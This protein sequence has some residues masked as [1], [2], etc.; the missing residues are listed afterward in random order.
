[1]NYI[2][3]ILFILITLSAVKIFQM[4]TVWGKLLAANIFSSNITVLVIVFSMVVKESMYLD[5]IIT[6]L[7]LNFVGTVLFT[8][9]IQSRRGVI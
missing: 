6:Y 9:H 8:K 4:N 5:L 3:F 1:M 2:V 7:L